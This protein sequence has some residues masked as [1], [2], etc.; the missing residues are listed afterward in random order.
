MEWNGKERK[1]KER[2]RRRGRKGMERNGGERKV[3]EGQ[4]IGED[5]REGKGRGE[6]YNITSP[7]LPPSFLFTTTP[8]AHMPDCGERLARQDPD[9]PTRCPD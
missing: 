8:G 9:Y 3:K 1:G 7:S 5:G 4:G 2:K 6:G